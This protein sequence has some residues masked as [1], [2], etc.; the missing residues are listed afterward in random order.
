MAYWMRFNRNSEQG[1]DKVVSILAEPNEGRVCALEA[2]A[3]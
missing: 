2:C 3:R 1:N